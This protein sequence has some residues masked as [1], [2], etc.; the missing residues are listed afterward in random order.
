MNPVSSADPFA[1]LNAAERFSLE[2]RWYQGH[3]WRYVGWLEEFV[4]RHHEEILAVAGPRAAVCT[5]VR[6]TQQV[7]REHGSI[8]LRGELEDQK[9]EIE[10][11][12][13]YRG[14][15]GE[16]DHIGICD[17]WARDH[18]VAW[19][20]YRILEYLFVADRCAEVVVVRLR[21]H[22]LPEDDDIALEA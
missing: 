2:L 11:E 21:Q 3:Q 4:T 13:W 22:A 17:A 5:L 10:R 6:A 8:N 7:I 19:R 14:E 18:A 16:F 20:R 9:A 15:N 12:L 1:P